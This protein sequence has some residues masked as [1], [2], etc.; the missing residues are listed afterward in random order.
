MV[1]VLLSGFSKLS[2]ANAIMTL[3][4]VSCYYMTLFNYSG[5][6]ARDVGLICRCFLSNIMPDSIFYDSIGW[7]T[8]FFE[9]DNHC[10]PQCKRDGFTCLIIIT[11]MGFGKP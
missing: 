10:L 11:S 3:T 1:L 2:L 8:T 9:G 4:P 6:K 7:G 5:K